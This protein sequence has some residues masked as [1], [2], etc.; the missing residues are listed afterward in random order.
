MSFQ[1]EPWSTEAFCREEFET[2]KKELARNIAQAQQ[3]NKHP[4]MSDQD[5]LS[6][7]CQCFVTDRNADYEMRKK[8]LDSFPI[9]LDWD[10]RLR[11]I[12]FRRVDDLI[13]ALMGEMHR[14]NYVYIPF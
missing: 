14:I 7:I 1:F 13:N 11:N 6:F 12:H 10:E 3:K 2:L 9:T 5:L 8:E 4:M